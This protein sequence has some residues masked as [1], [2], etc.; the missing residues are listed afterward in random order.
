MTATR[1]RRGGTTSPASTAMPAA[2]WSRCRAHD[3]GREEALDERCPAHLG[4]RRVEPPGPG[5][6][7]DHERRGGPRLERVGDRADVVPVEPADAGA[8]AVA[9]DQPRHEPVPV[10]VD[11]HELAA[12]AL[13]AHEEEVEHADQPGP[14]ELVD[15]VRDP[16]L[17]LRAGAEGD[18]HQLDRDG[19]GSH[20]ARLP[21]AATRRNG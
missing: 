9:V 2:R 14:L 17:E 15:L 13:A 20:G 3:L 5:V 12:L 10:V 21:G 6:L 1:S 8:E 18:G 11:A 16:P 7:E 19:S 4:D